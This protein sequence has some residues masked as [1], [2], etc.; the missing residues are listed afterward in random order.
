MIFL[1]K[2]YDFSNLS[3]FAALPK[4]DLSLGF[5]EFIKAV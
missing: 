4:Y 1:K 5:K 3:L 2:A